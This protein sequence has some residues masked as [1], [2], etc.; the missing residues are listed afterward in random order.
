MKRIISLIVVLA[1][2]VMSSFVFAAG[3]TAAPEKDPSA[4]PQIS[5]EEKKS[6]MLERVDQTIATM[7]EY[8]T[9]IDAAQNTAELKMCHQKRSHKRHTKKN[10]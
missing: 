3:E 10:N 5:F 7:N 9:C 4:K 1:F 8:R 6:R 2:I